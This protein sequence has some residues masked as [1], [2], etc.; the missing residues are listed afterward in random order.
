MGAAAISA[1]LVTATVSGC[2]EKPTN[3]TPSTL[4]TST[5][6]IASAGVLGNARKPDESC[7]KDAAAVDPS[8][9][10]REV[11]HAQGETE[12]PED[13]KRIVVLDAGAID[14]LCALGLH[15]IAG[16]RWRTKRPLPRRTW[17]PRSTTCRRS[18]RWR[19]RIWPRSVPP[20]PI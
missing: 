6:K 8:A 13:A 2:T 20:S 11:R 18:D 19:R 17:A 4:A 1:A 15:R 3:E 7:A 5:T 14:T 10:R 9:P 12:V 16:V